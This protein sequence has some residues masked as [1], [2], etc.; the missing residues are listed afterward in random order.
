LKIGYQTAKP[1]VSK[2]KDVHDFYATLQFNNRSYFDVGIAVSRFN[3][4]R[5]WNWLLEPADPNRWST[6]APTVNAFWE[7]TENSITFPAGVLQV[8]I[9]SDE[10]PAYVSF[11]A[12]GSA[13][14]HELT[15]GFD[16]VGA[17]YDENGAYQQW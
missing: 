1:N 15:H 4:N 17:L 13:A 8:P 7:D 11:G 5:T 12:Y 9:F 6:A 10:L 3:R 16:N 14:G 2:P